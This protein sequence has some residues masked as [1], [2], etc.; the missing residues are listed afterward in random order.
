M[1]SITTAQPDTSSRVNVADKRMINAKTDVNQLIPFK[2]G[3]AWSAYLESS[4]SHW[5]PKK[6][7][8]DK[9][10]AAMDSLHSSVKGPIVRVMGYMALHDNAGAE[11]NTLSA[12]RY[13]TAPECRQYMLRQAFEETLQGVTAEHLLAR[14]SVSESAAVDAYMARAGSA[15]REAIIKSYADTLADRHLETKTPEGGRAFL[16]AFVGHTLV[17]AGLGM[18]ADLTKLS[19]SHEAGIGTDLSELVQ[20]MMH[21]KAGHIDFGVKVINSIVS[22]EP[23]LWTKALQDEVSQT[24]F[25]AAEAEKRTGCDDKECSILGI[26]A[27]ALEKQIEYTANHLARS[28]GLPEL[29]M[30]AQN[31]LPWAAKQSGFTKK[32]VVAQTKEELA[33]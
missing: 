27:K 24:I 1:K 17:G 7:Q 2:Y 25:D 19:V 26:E 3:W 23:T 22:E 6:W 16:K 11:A 28:I 32:A 30:S 5:S 29:Y 15:E 10:R 20:K 33:W 12:Y 14:L 4:K 13:I 9:L 8:F 31:A 21:D 18:Y